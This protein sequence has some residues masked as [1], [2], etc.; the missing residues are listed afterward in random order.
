MFFVVVV[1]VWMDY[2]LVVVVV[3]EFCCWLVGWLVMR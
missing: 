3:E 1:T 2:Q